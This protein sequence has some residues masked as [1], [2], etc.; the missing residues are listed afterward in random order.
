MNMVMIIMKESLEDEVRDLL[1]Q[2]DVTGFT[3]MHQVIGQGEAG[4]TLD[5]LAWPG[6]ND[7][8]L[9]AMPEHKAREVIEALLRFRNETM[10]R[11]H[12]AKVPLRVF[13]LPCEQVV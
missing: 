6:F 7:L 4:P 3:E 11:Q 1:K 5:S 12:G 8:I 9:A 10:E 13:S 2:H